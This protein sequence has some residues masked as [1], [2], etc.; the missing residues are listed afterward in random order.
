MRL[1]EIAF[2][3]ER[4]ALAEI[5]REDQQYLRWISFEYRGPWKFGNRLVDSIIKNTQL[6]HGY[7]LQRATYFFLTE[8]EKE[9]L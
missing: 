1:S 8:E 9:F 5:V 7:K 3:V 4:K 2:I 6:P